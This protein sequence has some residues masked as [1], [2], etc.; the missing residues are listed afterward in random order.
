MHDVGHATRNVDDDRHGLVRE[1]HDALRRL[2]S[3][4]SNANDAPPTA[5]QPL[6]EPSVRP[7]TNCLRKAKNTM[8][9]GNAAIIAPAASR[10]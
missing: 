2:A 3:H 10:L 8:S 5:A 6:V 1:V 9:V 4:L 7:E